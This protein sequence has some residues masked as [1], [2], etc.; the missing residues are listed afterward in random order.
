MESAGKTGAYEKRIMMAL[1]RMMHRH[2]YFN[3]TIIT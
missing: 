1:H 3:Y 2:S